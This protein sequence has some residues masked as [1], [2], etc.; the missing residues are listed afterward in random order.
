MK[1]AIRGS[2]RVQLQTDKDQILQDINQY[3]LWKLNATDSQDEAGI[4]VFVFELWLENNTDEVALW[5]Q[6]KT[7]CNTFGGTVD[8]HDCTHDEPSPRPCVIAE[9][10]AR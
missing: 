4:S 2:L 3:P 8:R 10:Y 7:H 9:T 6:V 5:E 1:K